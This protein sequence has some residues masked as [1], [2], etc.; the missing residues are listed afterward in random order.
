MIECSI[1]KLYILRMLV[2]RCGSAMTVRWLSVYK[3]IITIATNFCAVWNSCSKADSDRLVR[4]QLSGDCSSDS[5]SENSSAHEIVDTAEIGLAYS[6]LE[7]EKTKAF[8]VVAVNPRTR[9]TVPS[10]ATSAV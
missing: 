5:A 2:S 1:F 4:L 6:G 8:D 7:A 9:T 10:R 3:A